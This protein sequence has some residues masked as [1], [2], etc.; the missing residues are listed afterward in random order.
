MKKH[1]LMK[2]LGLKIVAFI[3]AVFLWLIVVNLDNPVTSSRFSEIPVTIVNDDIITSAGDVYQVVGDQT[4]S[5]VV[6]APRE[7]CETLKADDIVVTADI[8]QMDTSTGLVP[9]TVD[10]PGYDSDDYESAVSTPRNLQIQREKS[11]KKVMTLTVSTDG[12]TPRDGYMI[13]DVTVS[14]EKVTITGAESVLEQIN[15]AVAWVEVTDLW[16]DVEESAEL[17]L[18]DMN[19]NVMN[20][21]QLETNL[22]EDGITVSVEAL[23]VKSVPVVFDVTGTPADGHQYTGCYT[24]PEAVQIC[25]RS[26]AVDAVEE[27]DI[28][29]SV[30]NINNADDVITKTV[31]ITPYLPEGVSLVEESAANV[32]VTVMIEQEGTRTINFLVR[33]IKISDL[34]EDLQVSYEPDAEISLRFQGDEARLETLDISNAVTVDMG[35]Y[36][37]PGVYDVP[38]R[39]NLPE[40]VTL[41]ETV[42]VSLT[43]EKKETDSST[44]NT[45]DE[46]TQNGQQN[47]E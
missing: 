34:A 10:L 6:R 13:G 24:E 8:K 26:D 17:I 42:T 43:L 3:F 35:D 41:A 25:G 28:P 16:K 9:I 40:G 21:A 45:E 15:R 46:G 23:K 5:V 31:D 18:Y 20:Q 7:L 12:I 11:G 33:S 47:S 32:T 36:T 2:N 29:A 14:P 44:S 19:G 27:I 38:V 39:V 4:V 30:I 37:M 1:K 22:G